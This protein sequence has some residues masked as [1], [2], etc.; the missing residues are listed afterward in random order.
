MKPG[1]DA[2]DHLVLRVND[3]AKTV[4]FYVD[5]LGMRAERFRGADGSE[6]LAL[7]Y[8]VQK[9]NLHAADSEIEPR[10]RAAVPGSADLCFLSGVS[11][12]DWLLHL[13]GC[14]VEIELGPVQRRGAV[15]PVCSV[16]I[17]DP[18]GNLIEIAN[19]R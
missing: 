1:L 5:V 16:Y 17:R 14:G 12:A 13:D 8:G 15:G 11:I 7:G 2:L 6:R 18:D 9:I 3:V 19:Q 10:A 4:T